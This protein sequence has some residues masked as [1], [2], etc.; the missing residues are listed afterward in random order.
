MMHHSYVHYGNTGG[1]GY[2]DQ[3]Q[4]QTLVTF[5][6]RQLD[7]RQRTGSHFDGK[8]ESFVT[9]VRLEGLLECRKESAIFVKGEGDRFH[10]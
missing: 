3:E 10:R 4:E 5:P 1:S 9:A 6:R 8:K 7:T 2:Q